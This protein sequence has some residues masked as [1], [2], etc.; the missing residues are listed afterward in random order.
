MLDQHGSRESASGDSE[1]PRLI[2]L[3]D[4]VLQS[5]EAVSRPAGNGMALVAPLLARRSVIGAVGLILARPT[6][7]S[8]QNTF[9]ALCAVAALA[10]EGARLVAAADQNR[11]RWEEALD[12]LSLA[13]CLLDPTGRVERANSG[14][15]ELLRLPASGSIGQHWRDLVPTDWHGQ[16][17]DALTAEQPQQVELRFQE[18][19]IVLTAFRGGPSEP[20][21]VVLLLEDDTER[22]QLQDRLIQSERLSAIGQLI[23]GVAHDL[24]NPL[25]S[26]VGFADFLAERPDVPPRIKEPLRVI[27]QEAE[28]ASQI[29]KNLLS[30]ARRRDTRQSV[31][32]A[33]LIHSTLDLFRNQLGADRV[34]LEVDLEPNLPLLDLNPNQI[35]QVFVNLIQNAAQAI[36][37]GGQ[38]GVIRIVGRRWMD[39]VAVD[40]VDDGP[41][42]PPEDAA[43]AFEP[44]FTTKSEGEGTGLGLSISQGI[45]KEHGG[46]ITLSTVP[47]AGSTVTIELPAPV[48]PPRTPLTDPATEHVPPLSVLVVDDEP[49]ILHYIRAT[50][51]A[52]GHTV[53]TASDGQDGLARALGERFDLIISDLRMPRLGGREFYE[54]LATQAPARGPA[55][56][57]LHRRYGAGRYPRFPRSLG[58]ALPAETLQP[59]GTARRPARRLPVIPT[60]VHLS[61]GREW[62]GGER[63]VLLLATTLASAHQRPQRLITRRQSP[64]AA[65]AHAAGLTVHPV[66][67]GT[68]WDPRVLVALSRQLHDTAGLR[69]LHAHD[70]HALGLALVMGRLQRIPVVATRRSMTPAGPLWRQ[71]DQVV[72]ISGAVADRLQ[73]DGVPAGRITVV[74]SALPDDQL[75]PARP[76]APAGPA[77][78][79]I[80]IGALTAEKGHATL[81][82]AMAGLD[83]PAARLVLLG[84]G[85][86]EPALR[87]QAERLG[88]ATR[89]SFAGDV[90]HPVARLHEADLFVQPSLREGLGTAVLAA[91]AAGV[92]VVASRTGGLVELLEDGA[93]L[94]VPTGHAAALTGAIRCALVDA[95]LREA[96]VR[97]AHGRVAQY[98]AR[99]MADQMMD[100]YGSVHCDP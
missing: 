39:G 34:L 43:R 90:E 50:L 18:R 60:V 26:V 55:H 74:P 29:V 49:H 33:P 32:L 92:P 52:W 31:N 5:G 59:G 99:R 41:G 87:R 48:R 71:A 89:V 84:S 62:R 21:R 63:Q 22:R 40:V 77:P 86:E 10:L 16:V 51:E 46:R 98:G 37:A 61:R 85:P 83:L 58:P 30:F 25:T 3:L 24:N 9:V 73:Q 81:L 38:P 8:E 78:L 53:S 72:A 7:P 64:L 68:A 28:R 42:M 91:M 57:I 56:G 94:L 93:G 11:I 15:R 19:A 44:F 47:G 82:T 4:D 100:V 20:G 76:A 12:T 2:Q 17:A 54:T 80:A 96:L 79:V 88:I 36:T 70:S 69:L 6:Q 65:A 75:Q 66:A 27:Q 97:T 45:V 13:I 23:A 1:H 67:W 35:Q 95:T 14:F